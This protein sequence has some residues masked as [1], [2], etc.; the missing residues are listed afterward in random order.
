MEGSELLQ[1]RLKEQ[2]LAQ[3]KQEGKGRGTTSERTTWPKASE[4]QK[5]IRT[6]GVQ[7]ADKWTSTRP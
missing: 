3:Q 6:K 4:Q 1:E 2:S 7:D 5:P